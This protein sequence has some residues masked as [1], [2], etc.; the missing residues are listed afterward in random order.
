[1][2]WAGSI[3]QVI[4]PMQQFLQHRPRSH[5]RARCRSRKRR[6]RWLEH[7]PRSHDRARCRSRKRRTRWLEH[8]PRSHDRDRCRSSKSS[9]QMRNKSSSRNE[10]GDWC[11]E[12]CND[13]LGF[14]LFHCPKL[15][16]SSPRSSAPRDGREGSLEELQDN[17]EQNSGWCHLYSFHYRLSIDYSPIYTS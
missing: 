17:R 2:G 15:M 9:S 16:V 5:D 4:S 13:S 1:M 10:H 12:R 8:R 11:Q 14:R 3:P 6:T 7:R